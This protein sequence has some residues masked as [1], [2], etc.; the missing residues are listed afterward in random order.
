[1]TTPETPTA[2]TP[3]TPTQALTGIALGKMIFE[4]GNDNAGV[5]P[6][7]S[8]IAKITVQ[9]CKNCHGD[10]A[11]GNKKLGAPD[12]RGSVLQPDFNDITFARAVT[13]G[14]D[15]SGKRLESKMPRFDATP[16]DTAALWLYVNSLK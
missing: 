12:I 5:I 11:N 8:G 16:E 10:D 1:M 4:T 3:A 15:D 2:S 9:A 13:T 7:K 6:H 14:V